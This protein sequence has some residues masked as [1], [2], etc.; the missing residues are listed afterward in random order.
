M[1][2]AFCGSDAELDVD[3]VYPCT[4]LGSTP[5]ILGCAEKDAHVPAAR[6]TRTADMLTRSGA[7]VHAQLYPGTQH[8]I[9]EASAA[10]ARSLLNAER[11]KRRGGGGGTSLT[12]DPYQ[13]LFGFKAQLLSEAIPN[14]VPRNQRSPRFV[15]HGLVA[16]C[17][18]GSPFCA[19]RGENLVTWFYR[20][21]PSVASH[22]AF[23]PLPQPHLK[24]DFCCP[25]SSLTPEPVRWRC[26]PPPKDAA[27]K[28]D[29]VES[30]FTLAGSGNPM[31][32]KGL[33]IHTYS[34]NKDMVDRS[35]Y[36]ADGDLLVVPELGALDIR[37]EFG[38]LRVA[39]GEIF[40]LPRGLKMTVALPEGQG[41]GF[42]GELFESTHFQLPNLGP[43]GSNGLAAARHF[44][45]PTAAFEDRA[46]PDYELISKFGGDLHVAPLQ[47]SPYDVVGWSGNYHPAK[48]DLMQFMAFGSVTWDHADPSTHTVLTCPVVA[49][50][51]ASAFD[52]VCFRPRWDAVTHTWRP[53]YWHR[54]MATEFN[55]IIKINNPYSG[56]AQGVHWLTPCMTAHGISAA[57]H[58]GFGGA[59]PDDEPRFISSDSIWIMFE[60]VYPMILQDQ[61][62]EA[63]HRDANYR[64]FFAGVPR[65]F[66]PP[67]E[68]GAGEEKES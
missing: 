2:G 66:R 11:A 12:T 18:N 25:G 33:A 50:N 20:V 26:P 3:G 54:N 27:V 1:S 44:Q 13:Y 40:V 9:Y 34:A 45:V 62:A 58:N 36:D 49:Q 55:A 67:D 10:R 60:T 29:F 37:T 64:E 47:F 57:S 65:R 52:F 21:H 6:V 38:F 14:T 28:R 15:P 35:F 23:R 4:A 48:Y 59:P 41:R 17:I 31:S 53:P 46:C 39:P 24:G 56:F 16:E 22:G 30:L 42:V 32:V 43:L 51:G 5:V 68:V 19:P 61:A 7:Q 8:R 63:P